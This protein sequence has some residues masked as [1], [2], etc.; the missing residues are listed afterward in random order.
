MCVRESLG[1][2]TGV[3]PSQRRLGAGDGHARS[4]PGS[5]GNPGAPK[6]TKGKQDA[7]RQEGRYRKRMG[8]ECL[9][10][11]KRC[12]GILTEYCWGP[13]DKERLYDS[14]K[15]CLRP[16][17]PL[18]H[19][20]S[21]ISTLCHSTAQSHSITLGHQNIMI[22]PCW[23]VAAVLRNVSTLVGDLNIRQMALI[24]LQGPIH[25]R[26]FEPILKSDT[27]NLAV[28]QQLL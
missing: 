8:S 13:T 18:T 6:R 15:D 25:L 14:W 5:V 21:N 2:R 7:D 10:M 12:A 9:P 17:M 23:P 28:L 3:S 27:N 16:Q 26:S 20:K 19:L 24:P 4:L 11:K 1:R 22:S